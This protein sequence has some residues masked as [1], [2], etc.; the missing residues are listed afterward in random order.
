MT[1]PITGGC[2][3]GAIRYRIDAPVT[4]LRQCHCNNCQ[5]A[6]GSVGTVGAAIP[7]AA[8]HLTQGT[9]R[10]YSAVVD[11][12]RTLHRFFCGECGSPLYSQRANTPEN[13]VVRAG[14]FDDPEGLKITLHIWTSKARSWHPIDPGA[15]QLPGQPA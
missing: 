13:M 12:G 15:K 5:K 2:L 7:S 8:F 11:S 3:C 1:Q 14:T 4:E 6:S 10:R 9:P